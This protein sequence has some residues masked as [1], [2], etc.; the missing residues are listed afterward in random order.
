MLAQ[1]KSLL[2]LRNFELE[3][4]DL[5]LKKLDV[6]PG[7]LTLESEALVKQFPSA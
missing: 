4:M 7:K 1:A 5:T 2:D 3:G 6:Q